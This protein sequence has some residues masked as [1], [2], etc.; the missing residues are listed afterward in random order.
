MSPISRFFRFPS[1]AGLA[2]LAFGAAGCGGKVVSHAVSPDG[3]R[4]AEVRSHWSL[5]PPSQSLWLAPSP[6]ERPRRIAR[7]GGDTDW[8]DEIAWSP[9]GS[10]VAFLIRGAFLD[11]YNAADGR[12]LVRH[13]LVE[14]DGYPGSREARHVKLLAGGVFEFEDCRRESSDCRRKRSSGLG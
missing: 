6:A 9:D 11:V 12:R 3:R 8:C 5:D 13:N 2:L 10:R 14:L 7:L 1:L 4:V